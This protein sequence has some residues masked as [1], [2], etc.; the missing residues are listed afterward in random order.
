MNYMDAVEL[1]DIKLEAGEKLTNKDVF[2]LFFGHEV[3]TTLCMSPVDF[4]CTGMDC[5]DCK[6]HDW[7]NETYMPMTEKNRRLI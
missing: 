7:W 5:K 3:E 2:K 4:D 1:I 6:W